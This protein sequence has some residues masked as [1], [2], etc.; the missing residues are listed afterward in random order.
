MF[1]RA[2]EYIPTFVRSVWYYTYISAFLHT[3]YNTHYVL[4]FLFS[5][6][7]IILTTNEPVFAPF[8]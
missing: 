6:R 8:P 7:D 2:V 1:I 4:K 3:Q 5:F